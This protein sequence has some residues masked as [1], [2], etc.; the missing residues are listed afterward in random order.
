MTYLIEMR[1]KLKMVVRG[2]GV[3]HRMNLS[4]DVLWFL[5][6]DVPDLLDRYEAS[7]IINQQLME[8]VGELEK[9]VK[10]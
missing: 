9:R 7:M 4:Q 5:E 3:L 8:Q 2:L 6:K 1:N 10:G